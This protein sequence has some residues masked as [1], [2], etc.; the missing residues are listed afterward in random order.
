MDCEWKRTLYSGITQKI[1][2]NIDDKLPSSEQFI[3]FSICAAAHT[4]HGLWWAQWLLVAPRFSKHLQPG[5]DTFS[6]CWRLVARCRLFKVATSPS[7][8]RP[9][10]VMQHTLSQCQQLALYARSISPGT[11][12]HRP[13]PHT[14]VLQ[15]SAL[16]AQVDLITI[17]RLCGICCWGATRGRWGPIGRRQTAQGPNECATDWCTMCECGYECASVSVCVLIQDIGLSYYTTVTSHRCGGRTRGAVYI[18]WN[19]SSALSWYAL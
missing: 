9:H 5:P 14:V 7:R 10:L 12:P 19:V 13:T 8:P 4:F 2:G 3:R 18:I 17:I 6:F 15:S 1:N 16:C 11:L